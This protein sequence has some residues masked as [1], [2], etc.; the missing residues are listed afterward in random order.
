MIDGVDAIRR[1]H[2]NGSRRLKSTHH[3]ISC[4]CFS[5]T[6][7][8]RSWRSAQRSAFLSGYHENVGFLCSR[9]LCVQHGMW[10]DV[11][12]S[13]S[14]CRVVLKLGTSQMMENRLPDARELSYQHLMAGSENKHSRCSSSASGIPVEETRFLQSME[15][16]IQC[17]RPRSKRHFQS[18][19]ETSIFT[20]RVLSCYC[21]H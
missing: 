6:W 15:F 10:T 17:H 21:P 16:Y 5:L 18:S 4:F 19:R 9:L 20:I 7:D 13:S 12:V 11:Q 8:I 14:H 1:K 2:S 3:P